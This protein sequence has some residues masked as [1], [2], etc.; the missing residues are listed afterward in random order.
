M[1]EVGKRKTYNV[2]LIVD[3]GTF[4]PK[5]EEDNFNYSNKNHMGNDWCEPD[6]SY[7]F[8]NLFN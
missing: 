4:I 3:H 5:F 2:V 6:V 1:N 7:S 8:I